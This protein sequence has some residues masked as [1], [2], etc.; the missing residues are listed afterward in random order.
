M[1]PALMRTLVGAGVGAGVGGI[2]SDRGNTLGGMVGGALL[3]A[4]GGRYGGAGMRMHNRWTKSQYGFGGLTNRMGDRLGYFGSGAWGQMRADWRSM[5]GAASNNWNKINIDK[6][7]TV[8]RQAANTITDTAKNTGATV[9]RT[10]RS[11]WDRM[12]NFSFRGS[13]TSTARASNTI[14]SPSKYTQG[15]RVPGSGPRS[16]AIWGGG[17][18]MYTRRA[19]Q[20]RG[21]M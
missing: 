14:P 16:Q 21:M 12:R 2:F 18:S 20:H 10:G 19:M 3:G 8:A 6:A 7:R 13:T 17:G 1:N 11:I 15:I 9:S 4:A 5:S